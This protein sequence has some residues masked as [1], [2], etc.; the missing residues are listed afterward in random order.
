M[1]SKQFKT[2]AALMLFA[3]S[4]AAQMAMPPLPVDPDVRIG[5]LSNGLT[6]YI[7]HN[8]KPEHQA[9]FYIAQKVGSIQEEDNQL[10]LAHFLEHMAFNGSTHFPGNRLTDYLEEKGVNFGG[11]VNA[12]TSF[13]ETVYN[14]DNVPTDKDAQLVDSCLWILRDWSNGLLLEDKEIDKERGVIY[15]EWQMR[16][17]PQYRFLEKYLDKLTSGSKYGKRMP[18][19]TMDIVQ[20]FPYKDLRD[21]YKKWYHPSLQGIIVV[22]DIDVDKIEARI[23]EIFSGI[24]NPENEAKREYYTI[25]QNNEAIY[26]TY[27]DKEQTSTEVSI[28]FKHEI[29]PDSVKNNVQYLATCYIDN[30]VSMMTNA[31]LSEM[32]Q[33]A[34]APFASANSHNGNF[35]SKGGAAFEFNAVPKEGKEIESLKA[36][37]REAMRVRNFGFTAT[38]YDRAK[39][40]YLSQLEKVLSNADKQ[41]N[42]T[43]VSKYVRNFLDNEPNLSF[44][45]NYEIAKQLLPN[46]PVEA[47][48]MY[49]KEYISATDTNFV[50]TIVSP[51]VEGKAGVTADDMKKAVDEV[52]KETLTAYVD[53]VKN[54][55]LIAKLPKSGKIKGEVKDDKYGVTVLTLSNGA[56]VILKKTD[57]KNDQVLLSA[58]SFGGTSLYP[59]TESVNLNNVIGVM[60]SLGLGNF[61]P[62]ELQKALAGKQANISPS[63]GLTSEGFSGSSTPKDVETMLQMLYLNFTAPSTSPEAKSGFEAYKN[64]LRASLANAEK[65]PMTTLKDSLISYIYDGNLRSLPMKLADV[66]KIDY[67]RVRQIFAE[68]FANP[69]DFTFAIIGNYDEAT[70]RPLIC[71]YIASIPGKK[72]S[73]KFKAGQ[74]KF[75]NGKI[76]R[77]IERKMEAPQAYVINEIHYTTDAT[78]RNSVLTEIASSILS[79]F[80]NKE[81]REDRGLAYYAGANGSAS[82]SEIPGK[83]EV[84][85]EIVTPAKPEYTA[86]AQNIIDE[87]LNKIVAEGVKQED[88]DKSKEYILK[89]HKESLKSNSYWSSV[90]MSQYMHDLD[91]MTNFEEIVNKISVFDVKLFIEDMLKNGDRVNFTMNPEGT[92]QKSELPKEDEKN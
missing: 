22:G 30:L 81:I 36:I 8:E 70:I 92:V 31:R 6:Y 89:N 64:S 5:K 87:Q 10:G 26:V 19:G 43:F 24:N 80:Y 60:N 35:M 44:A 83:F 1:K 49:V 72:A 32:A 13:D 33:K 3:S 74:L 82:V 42:Q 11:D 90:I 78:I 14:I 46:I 73:E 77:I 75:H 27:Q 47:I 61:T 15:G 16:T 52:R 12:Y 84:S 51:E 76:A 53:N 39:T 85:M 23:K 29:T 56:R 58:M 59:A 25:P 79:V 7:R 67:D 86:M 4:A 57:F 66:D 28:M 91:Q 37:M 41:Y 69:G 40:E 21:Y 18:I 71:Q 50:S 2:F 34:D 17:G 48:N 62:S 68:R 45:Q 63:L 20:N 55:P 65:S 38:E 54:E 88:L 9:C